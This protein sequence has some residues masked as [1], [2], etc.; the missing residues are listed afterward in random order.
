TTKIDVLP[1]SAIRN[2][3]QTDY[4]A[5]VLDCREDEATTMGRRIL[6]GD[7]YGRVIVPK[8]DGREFCEN[9][10]QA[11]ERYRLAGSSNTAPEPGPTA[12][13][14]EALPIREATEPFDTTT[15]FNNSEPI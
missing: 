5:I 13:Q 12:A 14:P 10:K 6:T 9:A 11:L 8:K 3:W 7:R 1:W 4:H 15:R 2:V